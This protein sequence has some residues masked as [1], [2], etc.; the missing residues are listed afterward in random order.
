MSVRLMNVYGAPLLLRHAY[1]R[2][3]DMRAI[4]FVMML[5]LMIFRRRRCHAAIYDYAT[6][7]IDYVVYK[8]QNN[9]HHHDASML[10]RLPLI[11]AATPRAA[12]RYACAFVNRA[13]RAR[14]LR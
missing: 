3:C 9:H 13:P 5:R 12:R 8:S 11:I 2:Y 10:R 6:I 14:I 1:E 7:C 4:L